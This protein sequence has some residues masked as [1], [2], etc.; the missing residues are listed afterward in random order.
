[1][2]FIYYFFTIKSSTA[3]VENTIPVAPQDTLFQEVL[4]YQ[5]HFQNSFYYVCMGD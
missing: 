3:L 5:N 1:M 4:A 2:K